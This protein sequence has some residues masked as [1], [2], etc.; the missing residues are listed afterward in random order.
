MEHNSGARPEAQAWFEPL[1]DHII[2]AFEAM[3]DALPAGTPLP[4]CRAGR[5][6]RTPWKR[7]DHSGAPAAAVSWQ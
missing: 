2:A 5:F 4:I 3:E 7:T 1:R 6:K